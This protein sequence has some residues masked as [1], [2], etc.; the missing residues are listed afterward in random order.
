MFSPM[1]IGHENLG[2]Y[3][4]NRPMDPLWVMIYPQKPWLQPSIHSSALEAPESGEHPEVPTN[5]VTKGP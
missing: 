1:K 2:K 4:Y 3:I 5:S